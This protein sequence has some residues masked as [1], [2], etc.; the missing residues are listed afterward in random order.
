MSP[1]EPYRMTESVEVPVGPPDAF[2]R[3]TDE[4]DEWWGHGP[5]DSHASWRLVERRFEGRV[6]GRLLED[7]R[8]EV[9]VLGTVT[10]W[11]PGARVGTDSPLV[12][13]DDLDAHPRRARAAG[14]QIVE[15]VHEHGYRAY[16]A[17]DCEGRRWVFA[18]S[19]PRMGQEPDPSRTRSRPAPP[20]ELSR[21]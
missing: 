13:V 12:L 1:T 6:G 5:V 16:T 4:F 2:A 18:Q 20:V 9:R 21:P 11:E 17:A 19:G 10:A 8:D 3:F 15:P 14:A 7:Y